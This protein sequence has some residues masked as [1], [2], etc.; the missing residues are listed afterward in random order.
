MVAYYL[1]AGKILNY[2]S[3][4][5]PDDDYEKIIS[6][7][8]DARTKLNL[9]YLYVLALDDNG[10]LIYIYDTIEEN[11]QGQTREKLGAMVP[12]ENKE[13]VYKGVS[14][15]NLQIYRDEYFG[16]L[17][18]AFVAVKD[19]E[20]KD[21]AFIGL[22]ISEIRLMKEIN[23]LVYRLIFY[24]GLILIFSSLALYLCIE[25]FV[26]K[27]IE[28][29]SKFT[30]AFVES[31]H[32]EIKKDKIFVK[33]KNE[34]GALAL[35][36]N[37]MISDIKIYI[38]NIKGIVAKEEQITTELKIAGK[39]QNSMLPHDLTNFLKNKEFDVYACMYPAKLVGG[40]LY[41][42]FMIDDKNLAF[43]IADISGK[44]ISAA[45]FMV[46]VKMLIKGYATSGSDPGDIFFNVNNYLY[47]G[48]NLGMFATAFLG[49]INLETGNL[50]FS[51]AG[52]TSPMIKKMPEPFKFFEAE[53]HF[54]LGGM[55]NVKYESEKITLSSGDFVFLY[56]DGITEAFNSDNQIF[57][58]ERLI[59]LVNEIDY[60]NC[61]LKD[62][63]EK[64]KSK[65][66][67]FSV[68]V[69]QSD[70]ITMLIF[71]YNR[72]NEDYSTKNIP[73][74]VVDVKI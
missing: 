43:V 74:I 27:P 22:D 3:T 26:T 32:S 37:K 39:I 14:S 29:I 5:K 30:E 35:S 18:S 16:E 48:N 9:K 42:V 47:H 59:K 56:T 10:K 4:L 49:I 71:K 57:S 50:I 41:D 20:G 61:S 17:V 65:V 2:K 46:M 34:I 45:M 13:I 15:K 36:I 12:D 19:S 68:G 24:I 60:T 58:E 63:L 40:D 28:K 53:K 51:N 7:L 52:H 62:M 55:P 44:G 33:S 72:L 70:D 66:D 64:I 31:D 8:D 11:K 67:S 6:S 1:D 38:K 54:V 69:G 25:I 23:S 73:K 21:I